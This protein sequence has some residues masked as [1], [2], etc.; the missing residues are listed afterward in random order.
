LFVGITVCFV[1]FILR[2]TTNLYCGVI[3]FDPAL[4]LSRFLREK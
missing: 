1:V 2:G 4:R 3:R